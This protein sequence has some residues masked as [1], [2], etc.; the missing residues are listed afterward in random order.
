M[1]IL[2]ISDIHYHTNSI[3]INDYL[4][5]LLEVLEDLE[6]DLILITGDISHKIHEIE[7]VFK[8]LRAIF[9]DIPILF[10]PG[11]HD[12][13]QENKPKKV[14]DASIIKGNKKTIPTSKEKYYELLPDLC[15]KKRIHYLPNRPIIIDKI[16]FAGT[17]GWYN[18]SFRNK[19]FDHIVATDFADIF[20]LILTE[21]KVLQYA[22]AR[23]RMKKWKDQCWMD[24]YMIDWG[25][26]NNNQIFTD[27]KLT[28][29]FLKELTVD[30]KIIS[31]KSE[32]I[33]VALHHVPFSSF[34][35]HKGNINNDYFSAYLGSEL[36]GELL[37]KNQ[38]SNVFFGHTHYSQQKHISKKMKVYCCPIGLHSNLLDKSSYSRE[39]IKKK[40][41]NR[42]AVSIL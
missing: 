23:Y 14:H 3:I 30:I 29:I 16:G 2:G 26:D 28:N 42:I 39:A 41:K 12:I 20:D 17:I 27:E 32:K 38:I 35:T 24:H 15:E 10:V 37:K 9:A 13:W 1:K 6:P 33:I 21:K 5:M 18:Y 25:R 31:S 34:V 8:R 11:N 7:V 36:F 4:G 19:E 40:I 22:I